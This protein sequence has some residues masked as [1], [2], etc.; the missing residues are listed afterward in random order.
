MRMDESI[1]LLV[2]GTAPTRKESKMFLKVS[3]TRY[4][5]LDGKFEIVNIGGGLW[6]VSKQNDNDKFFSLYFDRPFNGALE[7]MAELRKAVA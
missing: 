5:S 4:I 6:S 7:A 2:G 3:H 1:V